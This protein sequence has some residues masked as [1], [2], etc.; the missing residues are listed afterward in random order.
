LFFQNRILTTSNFKP[1][2]GIGM[3]AEPCSWFYHH[4]FG[5]AATAGNDIALQFYFLPMYSLYAMAAVR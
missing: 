5:E 4:Y 2:T 1:Q 3:V